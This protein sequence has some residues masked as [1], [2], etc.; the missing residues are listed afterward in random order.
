MLA[1]ILH[2][3]NCCFDDL[4]PWRINRSYFLEREGEGGPFQMWRESAFQFKWERGT[5]SYV[6]WVDRIVCSET[7]ECY[8][9]YATLPR[10][11][12]LFF[13]Q[14]IPWKVICSPLI[15]AIYTCMYMCIV[16]L[17]KK[18]APENLKIARYLWERKNRNPTSF[19]FNRRQDICQILLDEGTKTSTKTT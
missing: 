12:N 18:H 16:K 13:I 9:F 19:F 7:P 1:A 11:W 15:L 6:N 5:R 17:T 8:F 3:R 10:E 4:L 2:G 14:S